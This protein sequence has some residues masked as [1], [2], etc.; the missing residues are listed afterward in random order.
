MQGPACLSGFGRYNGRLSL[1]QISEG[2]SLCIDNAAQ[3][4]GDAQILVRSERFARALA[5]LL[6]ACQE[7]GKALVLQGMSTIPPVEQKAWG[8]EW[9]KFR[10]HAEKG[11]SAALTEF[12]EFPWDEV[13]AALLGLLPW[14]TEDHDQQRGLLREKARQCCLY[15]DFLSDE[16]EWW[17]PSAISEPLVNR[18]MEYVTRVVGR[19]VL[20]RDIGLFSARA[21]AIRAEI[22]A[23][24]P[25]LRLRASRGDHVLPVFDE[26][27]LRRF[28]QR[29]VSEGVVADLPDDLAIMGRPWREFIGWASPE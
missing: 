5:L 27:A 29:V 11:L 10:Q 25:A 2:I 26:A 16:S 15:V 22:A 12:A 23:S 20:K 7:A 3:L 1:E 21:L 8:R 14:I 28:W 18:E 19:L 17:C 24:M 9:K 4:W 13:E 6:M